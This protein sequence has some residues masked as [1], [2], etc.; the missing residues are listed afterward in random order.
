M[1]CYAGLLMC[2]L[3]MVA[4]IAGCD[5]TSTSLLSEVSKAIV[6]ARSDSADAIM[7]QLQTHDRLKDGTGV[8]CLNARQ[9]QNGGGQGDLLRLRDGSCQD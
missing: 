7:S 6:T 1:R 2:G 8:N 5:L 9:V 4:T 3:G